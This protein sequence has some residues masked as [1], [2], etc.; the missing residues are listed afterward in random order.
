MRQHFF[1]FLLFHALV[2]LYVSRT[3]TRVT[4]SLNT[5]TK[6]QSVYLWGWAH[7]GRHER[8]EAEE[9]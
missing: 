3:Y 4:T 1:F 5:H 6:E 9:S 2:E 8:A 7:G